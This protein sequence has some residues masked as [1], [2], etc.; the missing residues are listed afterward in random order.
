M[1]ISHIYQYNLKFIAIKSLEYTQIMRVVV[2][3]V[4]M[5]EKKS[6]PF[7]LFDTRGVYIVYITF[8]D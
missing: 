2:G 4:E 6:C 1:Y 5:I 8:S 7:D 3:K